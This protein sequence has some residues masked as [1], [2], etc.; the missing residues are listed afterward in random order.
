VK[1]EAGARQKIMLFFDAVLIFGGARRENSQI[2][3]NYKRLS[4][5]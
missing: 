2:G 4:H 5:S 1:Q 3:N